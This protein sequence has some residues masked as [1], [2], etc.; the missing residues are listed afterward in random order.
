MSIPIGSKVVLLKGFIGEGVFG[1]PEVGSVGVVQEVIKGT[2]WF[3]VSWYKGVC[4]DKPIVEV[5]VL[6]MHK[7]DLK[8]IP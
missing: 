8:V 7:S 1:Y 5:I 4:R 6:N 3:K 2:D